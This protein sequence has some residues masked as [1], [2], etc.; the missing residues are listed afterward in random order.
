M[1]LTMFSRVGGIIAAGF[2][3][4]TLLTACT[5]TSA[6]QASAET[7]IRAN[8]GD[9]SPADPVLGGTFMVTDVEWQDD[10][11]ALVT[12]EDGHIMLTAR[13]E[14][15]ADDDG[16]EVMVES[17]VIVDDY[18]SGAM[19]STSMDSAMSA[20]GSAMTDSGAMMDDDDSMT[21]SGGAMMSAHAKAGVGE[22]CG[23]IAGILCDTGLTCEYDGTYP[24]ASGT[25]E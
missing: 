9:L 13:A 6:M 12:Y 17:F 2:M 15:E 11:T 23:G 1:T 18:G 7:Y 5:N 20:S 25:C 3:T 4:L 8:I 14:V 21:A 22:M 19:S 10:N 16:D 24:D